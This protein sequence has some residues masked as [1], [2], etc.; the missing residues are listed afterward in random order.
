MA[1]DK[2]DRCRQRHGAADQKRL[3]H[4]SA[5]FGQHYAPEPGKVPGAIIAPQS[6]F[7]FSMLWMECRR[8]AE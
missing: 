4:V 5:P 8:H 1:C 7:N 6:T 2:R 3:F